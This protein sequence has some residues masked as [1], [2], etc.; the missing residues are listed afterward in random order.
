MFC[1]ILLLIYSGL[2]QVLHRGLS[3]IGSQILFKKTLNTSMRTYG[4][5]LSLVFL[6]GTLVLIL[7][8]CDSTIRLL[9]P[10]LAWPVW[11]GFSPSLSLGFTIFAG[12]I[13][14]VAW[15]Y[16]E[17]IAARGWLKLHKKKETG[18]WAFGE[19]RSIVRQAQKLPAGLLMGITLGIALLEEL[20]WRGYM[21]TYATDILN[22]SA[23]HAIM[24]SSFAFGMNHL[25]YGL[26]NLFSKTLFG[27]FLSLMFLV[28]DSLFSSILCHQVF[29][30]MV[31]KFRIEWKP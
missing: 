2:V 10:T 26:A 16:T 19:T 13:A 23:Q 15:Y 24:I 21:V 1:F 3:V 8:V 18:L 22:L 5:I 17:I 29:N 28:S 30:L 31:F 25:G 11:F 12:V 7:S 9:V 14:G 6:I 27:G 20:L 4:P